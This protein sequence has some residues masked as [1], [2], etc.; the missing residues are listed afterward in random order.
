MY[1]TVKVSSIF[2][3]ICLRSNAKSAS[4]RHTATSFAIFVPF[5]KL[6]Y[7]AKDFLGFPKG[8]EN[9]WSVVFSRKSRRILFLSEKLPCEPFDLRD[10]SG[11]GCPPPPLAKNVVRM[12]CAKDHVSGFQRCNWFRSENAGK[13]EL[14][15]GVMA[16]VL[17]R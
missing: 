4:S 12:R 9:S 5:I 3:G 15:K 11:R 13:K 1:H 7:T 16:A 17:W 10:K 8:R 6:Q 2:S 14:E